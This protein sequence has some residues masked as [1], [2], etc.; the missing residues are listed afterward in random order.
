MNKIYWRKP[1][2]SGV[3]GSNRETRV[4]GLPMIYSNIYKIAQEY[5][6]ANNIYYELPTKTIVNSRTGEI[7]IVLREGYEIVL[8]PESKRDEII[9]NIYGEKNN[10]S[11]L[12][13]NKEDKVDSEQLVLLENKMS[14]KN[15]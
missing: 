5:G 3:I 7:Y 6:R 8:N 12:Q 14:D 11:P 10:N 13:K 15:E 2:F 9:V 4:F 1:V